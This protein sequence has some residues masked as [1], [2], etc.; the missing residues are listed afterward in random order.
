MAAR[1]VYLLMIFSLSG[2]RRAGDVLDEAANDAYAA[3]GGV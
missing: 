2:D 3:D 1:S